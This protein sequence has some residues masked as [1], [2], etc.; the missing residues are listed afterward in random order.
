M[1][2]T[3]VDSTIIAVDKI[4]MLHSNLLSVLTS[5]LK[6]DFGCTLRCR[7]YLI[8]MLLVFMVMVPATSTGKQLLY[9]RVLLD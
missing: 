9:V 6:L 3:C 2:L 8:K 7:P 1:L 5:K 4:Q